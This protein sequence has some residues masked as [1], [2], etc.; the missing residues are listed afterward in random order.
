MSQILC[1]AFYLSCV[2]YRAHA[3]EKTH[4]KQALCRALEKSMAKILFVVCF[5]H[6]AHQSIFLPFHP[7]NK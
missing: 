6:H 2:S 1:R 3:K 5:L 7:P 4:G